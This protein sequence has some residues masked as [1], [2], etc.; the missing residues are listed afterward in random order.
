[1]CARQDSQFFIMRCFNLQSE[2][3]VMIAVAA[4]EARCSIVWFYKTLLKSL[5]SAYIWNNF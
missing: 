4:T 3:S 2:L 1:M 5:H